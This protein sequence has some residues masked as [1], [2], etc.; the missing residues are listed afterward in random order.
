VSA[1]GSSSSAAGTPPR[2]EL[3]PARSAGPSAPDPFAGAYAATLALKRQAGSVSK[4]LAAGWIAVYRRSRPTN[5][6]LARPGFAYQL[7]IF[8]PSPAGALSL[9]V[10]GRLRP[11]R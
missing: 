9:A 11:V 6:Y 3:S 8:D 5:V 2:S 1:R 4:T 10:P 7:E